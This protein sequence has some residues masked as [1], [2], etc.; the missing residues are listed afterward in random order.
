MLRAASLL[1]IAL[2]ACIA[3]ER[4]PLTSAAYAC[5]EHS[6]PY[7]L[8]V[9]RR[10]GELRYF[11]AAHS[12]DPTDPQARAIEHAWAEL[13]PTLAFYEGPTHEPLADRDAAI[14]SGGEAGL[15]RFL[16]QRDGVPVRSL[17]P[18]HAAQTRAMIALGYTGEQVA[19]YFVL[20]HVAQWSQRNGDDL[21]GQL[22]TVLDHYSRVAGLESAPRSIAELD[23]MTR[24]WLP[25]LADWR[26]VDIG[27]F[28]PL[29]EDVPG[30]LDDMSRHLTALRD[31]AMIAA[32]EQAL[33][34]GER[35]FAV[36]GASHVVR[37]EPALHGGGTR[38]RRRC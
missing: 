10:R 37:Q 24:K 5:T 32:L 27:A 38:T 11:G 3:H 1:P 7:V 2:V 36:A 14:R 33:R 13:G 18:D 29:A 8:D 31:A 6:V 9:A 25:D 35:V 21:E 20:L 28:D 26:E 16:A 34:D 4:P 19:L 12:Y 23:A 15:V 22:R 30:W 17:D